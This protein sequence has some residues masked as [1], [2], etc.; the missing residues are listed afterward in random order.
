MVILA[1]DKSFFNEKQ[2][3]PTVNCIPDM[4]QKQIFTKIASENN[5]SI[6]NNATTILFDWPLK[7]SEPMDYSY[8]GISYYVDKNASTGA[9]IDYNNGTR[10]YDG[11]TGVD[12]FPQPYF[13]DMMDKSKVEIIAAA[14]GVIV[15][16][17]DGNY[18]R[19]CQSDYSYIGNGIIL[20]HS[21]GSQTWYWHLKNGSITSKLVGQAV[22]KG[23]YL[24]LVGSSGI[25]GGPHLHFEVRNSSNQI[26]D[27]FSNTP[28]NSLWVSQKPYWD[29]QIIRLM[30]HSGIPNP[31]PTCSANPVDITLEKK[32]FVSGENVYFAKYG[33]DWQPG[34]V[35][36]YRIIQPNGLIWQNV[37]Y[38]R[39]LDWQ[40]FS[41]NFH[42]VSYTLPNPAQTGVWK[43]QLITLGT[44]YETV[45]NVNTTQPYAMNSIICQ[46]TNVELMA[47]NGGQN[48]TYQWRLNNDTIN[49]ATGERFKPIQPGDYSVIA[50]LNGVPNTSSQTSIAICCP[51]LWT[52][53]STSNDYSNVGVVLRQAQVN[54][55]NITATNK[56]FPTSS[57]TYEAKSINLNSGF[58]VNSGA[59]FLARVGG[60]N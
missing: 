33:R 9:I 59:V 54:N 22:Q 24:G 8:Y 32:S 14:D 42:Y 2:L 41:S 10:T 34:Q 30:T 3:A 52:L 38:S 18:D 31:Y 50:T 49:G 55:G 40:T 29:S 15:F 36:N 19:R 16:R 44:T 13:W 47:M 23:E 21:D 7:Q 56:I 58:Q 28:S 25:S 4:I 43:F 27:P 48:Y 46:G 60:C 12:I 35:F 39:P 6:Y 17:Q 57:V 26:V 37:S 1:Q 5:F 45:F 11:H 53:Q 20:Q 51:S